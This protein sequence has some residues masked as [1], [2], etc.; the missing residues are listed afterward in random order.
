MP[1]PFLGLLLAVL[2]C[3]V[4]LGAQE[5]PPNI[6]ILFAD[7]LGINDLGCFGRQDQRIARQFVIREMALPCVLQQCLFGIQAGP[8]VID[9]TLEGELILGSLKRL[10]DIQLRQ[11]SPLILGL[12]MHTQGG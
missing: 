11:V 12:G 1:R 2:S 4:P 6:V 9:C 3:L 10:P 5:T 8:G 7:D